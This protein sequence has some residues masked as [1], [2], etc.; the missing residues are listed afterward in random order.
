MSLV[1][2]IMTDLYFYLDIISDLQK[3]DKNSAKNSKLSFSH[4]FQMLTFDHI[5]SP[6]SYAFFFAFVSGFFQLA[7]LITTFLFITE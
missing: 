6:I 4:V 1:G 2:K 3:G 5:C 7:W